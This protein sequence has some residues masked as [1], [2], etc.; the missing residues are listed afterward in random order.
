MDC[1]F[2]LLGKDF[3]MS[4]ELKLFIYFTFPDMMSF[5]EVNWDMTQADIYFVV[6]MLHKSKVT[7]ANFLRFIMQ[8]CYFL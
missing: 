7:E 3:P 1:S 6:S 8:K 5:D 2:M 4:Y